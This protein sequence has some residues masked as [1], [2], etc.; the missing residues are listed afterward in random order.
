MSD[1]NNGGYGFLAQRAYVYLREQSQPVE[2]DTLIRHVFSA[3]PGQNSARINVEVWRGVLPGILADTSRFQPL[4]GRMWALAGVGDEA[5]PI[6]DELASMEYIAL[7]TETTGLEASSNRIIEVAALH[8]LPDCNDNN[9]ADSYIRVVNPSRRL[10][11]FIVSHTGINQTMVDSAPSFAALAGDLRAFITERIIVGHNIGFDMAFLNAEMRRLGQPP[12]VNPRLDT[13]AMAVRLVNNLG[14]RNLTSV[15]AELGLPVGIRHRAEADARLARQVFCRLLTLARERG[16]VTRAALLEM[17]RPL[18]A[19]YWGRRKK[20]GSRF[21]PQAWQWPTDPLVQV[22]EVEPVGDWLASVPERAGVYIMRDENGN[23]LYVGKAGNLR[24]RVA[25]YYSRDEGV[26]RGLVGLREA[27]VKLELRTV[28]SELAAELLELELIVRLQPGYNTQRSAAAPR[29]YIRLH[30]PKHGLPTLKPADQPG[31]GFGPYANRSEVDDTLRLLRA[32]FP[33]LASKAAAITPAAYQ[34]QLAEA[35]AYLQGDDEPALARLRDR[36]YA[37]SATHDYVAESAARQLLAEVLRCREREPQAAAQVNEAIIVLPACDD[38]AREVFIVREGELRWHGPLPSTAI[39]DVLAARLA[40][41]WMVA[42]TSPPSS[43]PQKSPPP[44]SGEG[45]GGQVVPIQLSL[46][47]D[48]PKRKSHRDEVSNLV[49]RWL[50]AHPT[51]AG[52]LPMPTER[53]ATQNAL[54]HAARMIRG[55]DEG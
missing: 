49:I 40:E 48:A 14:K 53:E 51:H 16:I 44:I 42:G 33:A 12:F 23:A 4:G 11:A 34:A 47:G 28:G 21:D 31:E 13:L 39:E 19:E 24:R 32:I 25:N 18:G 26:L 5:A 27:T 30:Q 2:E 55:I 45:L 1:S 36:L 35:I 46:L 43:D 38:E 29:H 9:P 6:A 20:P 8:Y 10:P 54:R 7:D 22:R 15:A 50:Y 52:V 41:L 37:A 3:L 17:G